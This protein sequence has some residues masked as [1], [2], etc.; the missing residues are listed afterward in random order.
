MLKDITEAA[1]FF[2]SEDVQ[3]TDLELSGGRHLYLRIPTD[4]YQLVASRA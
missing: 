1:G 2:Q 4:A 3:D